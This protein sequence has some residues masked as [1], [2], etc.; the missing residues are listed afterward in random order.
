MATP[1]GQRIGIIT[2]AALML[3]STLAMFAMMILQTQNA[4]R[5][6]ERYQAATKQYEEAQKEV[7]QK[8]DAQTSELSAKYYP[9]FSQY[10]DKVGEFDRE[11]VKGEEVIKED[12][13][14]GE[15]A[16]IQG[17][18][19]FAAYYIGWTPDGK[20]FDQSVEDGKLI[21]PLPVESG[22]DNASLIT[23]WKEGMKGMK[24]GGVRLLTIPSDKAYGEQGSKDATGK[25]TISP[26][27]PLRFLVMAIDKPETI[28]QAE[29]PPE[30][31]QQYS[32]GY[33]L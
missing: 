10:V 20:I 23:G 29:I 26:N 17:D 4:E 11:S 24:I 3:V 33:G 15:G 31:L 2:I 8:M 9:I 21:Q 13:R 12:L 5:D 1:K 30:L 14:A 16:E 19:A 27:T 7:Q 25:E 28:P 22:L 32:Q 6:S 18:T